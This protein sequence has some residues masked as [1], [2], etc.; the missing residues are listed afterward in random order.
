[1]ANTSNNLNGRV[2]TALID[3]DLVVNTELGLIRLVREKFQDERAFKLEVLNRSDKEILSLLFSRKNPNPLSII[4]TEENLSDI[5]KLYDSF[6][7]SYK[8]DIIQRSN[9][10]S[11]IFKFA[12]YVVSSSANLGVNAFFAVSDDQERQSLIDHFGSMTKT[13]MKEDKNSLL[14]RDV[15]YIRDYR[16]F[17]D[18]NLQDKISRKKIYMSP[19]QFNLDYFEDV[20]NSLTSRNVFILFGKNYVNQGGTTN[21]PSEKAKGEAN[22]SPEN[23]K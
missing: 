9:S 12:K 20:T 15:Y 5:D 11:H 10:D 22:T 21:E 8:K 2:I 23:D 17:T 7:Q 1:M 16:F 4:S 3:F 14:G 13:I 6:F 19:R 18:H